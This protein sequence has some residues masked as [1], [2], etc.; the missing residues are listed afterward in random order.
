MKRYN[1]WIRGQVQGVWYRAS[2]RRKAV[3][4]G[5][6]GFVRNEPDGSVYA[7]A[8]GEEPLLQAFV[9]WCKEGPEM[10]QVEQVKVEEAPPRGCKTFDIQR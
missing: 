8:E 9:Q 2:A 1:L 3:D 4:L 6:C 5:L 10:A 7:E